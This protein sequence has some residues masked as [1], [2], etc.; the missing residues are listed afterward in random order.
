MHDPPCALFQSWLTVI[1]Y[2]TTLTKE[3]PIHTIG[4]V[5]PMFDQL[6][7]SFDG[8]DKYNRL[9]EV[10]P[11]DCDWALHPGGAS[12]LQGAQQALGLSADQLRASLEIYK[13]HGNSSSPTVLIVLDQLRKMG[14]GRDD[15]VA[16]SF[17]PGLT[18]E[19]C[20]MRRC[21]GK[22]PE[23][24]TT[25]TVSVINRRRSLSWRSFSAWARL[26]SVK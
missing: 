15:A 16:T 6:R 8:A 9:R 25:K 18:I 5:P 24:P 1:G 11:A 20:T 2:L 17:G 4:A 7:G 3:I 13:S 14:E 23:V 19:M 26:V 12:I 22:T 21:R 10:K